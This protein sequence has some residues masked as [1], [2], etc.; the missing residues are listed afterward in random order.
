MRNNIYELRD[1]FNIP[2]QLVCCNG[3]SVIGIEDW[4]IYL[5]RY[6]YPCRFSDMIPRFGRSV[7][8]LCVISNWLL[9]HIIDQHN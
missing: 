4:C 6:S 1:V 2:D 8:E 5:K 9:N 3:T 7:Q